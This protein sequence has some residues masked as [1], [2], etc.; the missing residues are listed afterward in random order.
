MI[1]GE[2]KLPPETNRWVIAQWEVN[3]KEEM[4]GGEGE[5]FGGDFVKRRTESSAGDKK[6]ILDRV[7]R[8]PTLRHRAKR[9]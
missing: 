3:R 4:L 2:D 8:N 9:G 6:N 7:T 1:G 5:R